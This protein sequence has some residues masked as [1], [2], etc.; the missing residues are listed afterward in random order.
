MASHAYKMHDVEKMFLELY[1]GNCTEKNISE[2][3]Q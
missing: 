3:Y 2:L 1:R